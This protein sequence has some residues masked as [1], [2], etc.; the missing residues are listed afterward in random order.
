MCQ[1]VTRDVGS[2]AV[3]NV[4][5]NGF[6][7]AIGLCASVCTSAILARS[8]GPADTGLYSYAMW[9]VASLGVVANGGLPAALTKYVSEYVGRGDALTAARICKR[10]LVVQLYVAGGAATLT[11]CFMLIK[12]PYRS[13]I[14]L[15]AVMLIA[16]ALQQSLGAALTGVLRFD[17]IAMVSLYVALASVA[18]IGLAA[19][20]RAG[21]TG[22]LWATVGGL[23]VAIWLYYR[24]VDKC[25]LK[26]SP[27]PAGPLPGKSDIFRQIRTFSF[28]ISYILLVDAIVWQRSEVLFL[29]WYSSLAQIGFY[30]LAYSIASK[31]SDAANTFSTILLPLYSASYGHSGFREV[32]ALFVRALKY[33][34]M[35]MVPLCFLGAAIAGPMVQFLYGERFLPLVVPLQILIVAQALTSIGVV[36]SP[37]IIG[38]GKQSIIAKWGTVVAILNIVLDLV[39]IPR[40]G[41]LGAAVANS[42]SQVVGV[43]IGAWYVV[44]LIETIFPVKTIVTIYLSAGIAVAPVAYL[45]TQKTLGMTV[46]IGSIL[47]GAVVYVALLVFAGQLGVQD[48]GVLKEAFLRRISA[49][50]LSTSLDRSLT[51]DPSLK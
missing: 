3:T 45:S 26:D 51:I 39:L 48:L 20:L 32:G 25:V 36:Q 24:E 19:L 30:A 49:S 23:I 50:K 11:A 40:Y 16:Q 14:G 44:S 33:L 5:F 46:L 6:R 10:L 47:F 29:K 2:K 12:S 34:Q 31:L 27:C 42:T 37:L 8:L 15:T 18:S 38:T 7:L 22:M 1:L 35:V 9:I 13:I 43:L 41:A 21:V 28:T 4:F 17:R